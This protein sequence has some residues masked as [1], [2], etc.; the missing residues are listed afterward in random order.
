MRLANRLD[1]NKTQFIKNY[2]Y[3]LYGFFDIFPKLNFNF[4]FTQKIDILSA[5]SLNYEFHFDKLTNI[6]I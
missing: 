3:C 5:Y 1:F 6:E 4:E 2:I